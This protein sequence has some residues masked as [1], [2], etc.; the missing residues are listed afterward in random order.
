MFDLRQLRN[1]ASNL[2][3]DTRYKGSNERFQLETCVKDG[4][5]G[6]EQVGLNFLVADSFSPFNL[7][8]CSCLTASVLSPCRVCE[9]SRPGKVLVLFLSHSKL[10]EKS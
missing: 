4:G 3:V 9:N 5:S 6:G 1:K 8:I 7:F 2:C 10:M